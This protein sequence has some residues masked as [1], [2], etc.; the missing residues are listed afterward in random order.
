MRRAL[1]KQWPRLSHWYHLH[2]PDVG[3]L[4]P[5]EINEYLAQLPPLPGATDA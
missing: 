4:T 1:L 5:D 3:D 2:P